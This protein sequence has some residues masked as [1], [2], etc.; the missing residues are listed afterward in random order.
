MFSQPF[1]R[2][3]LVLLAL[4]AASTVASAQNCPGKGTAVVNT[5]AA[6]LDIF[7]TVDSTVSGSILMNWMDP[8]LGR[9]SYAV[10]TEVVWLTAAPNSTINYVCTGSGNVDFSA[11]PS[12]GSVSGVCSSSSQSEAFAVLT[13]TPPENFFADI[14]VTGSGVAPLGFAAVV[15][16]NV[17]QKVNVPPNKQLSFIIAAFPGT[18]TGGGFPVVAFDVNCPGQSIADTFYMALAGAAATH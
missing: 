14:S 1:L 10:G 15:G 11:S 18:Y 13:T 8:N 17:V 9:S 3:G 16:G 6:P 7:L 4:C 5:T 2:I 12:G